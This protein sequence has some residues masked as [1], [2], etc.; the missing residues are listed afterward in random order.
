VT[1]AT[2]YDVRNGWGLWIASASAVVLIAN[3]SL[4][5]VGSV[6]LFRMASSPAQKRKH[7]GAAGLLF[8]I[9]GSLIALSLWVAISDYCLRADLNSGRYME[10]EGVIED[11]H[12]E[13][14]ARSNPMFFRV[15]ERWFA[16]P[17]GHP[18]DC[19]PH[20]AES[21]R[22]TFEPSADHAHAGPPAHD[23]LIMQ[24]THA[25]RIA[26]WG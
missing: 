22:L 7:I 23:I 17:Y 15:G 25:C 8:I 14:G 4:I 12:I 16:L 2:I 10:V 6:R 26:V 24:L 20:N 3:L 21:V 18:M 9:F 1:W 19:Y 5:L 11:A 13:A